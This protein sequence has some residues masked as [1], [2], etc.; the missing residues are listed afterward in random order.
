[1]EYTYRPFQIHLTISF[2]IRYS[3]FAHLGG[4]GLS[5]APEFQGLLWQVSRLLHT[6][7]PD[8]WESVIFPLS[9]VFDNPDNPHW[10]HRSP[11]FSDRSIC[12]MHTV[13]KINP[14][15][16]N[17]RIETI[18]IRLGRTGIS[19]DQLISSIYPPAEFLTTN[20]A[21]QSTICICIC[22][23]RARVRREVHSSEN[24]NYSAA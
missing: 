5:A 15:L 8:A 22:M 17:G 3:V 18:P 23:R 2:M 12:I 14:N 24:G 4:T 7:S 9:H 11:P 1:M 20:S 10:Q 16:P 19:A 13:Y 6:A 21:R